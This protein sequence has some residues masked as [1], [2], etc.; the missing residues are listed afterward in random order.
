MSDAPEVTF[1]APVKKKKVVKKK[2][3]RAAK[4]DTRPSA[5]F[6]GLAR[7]TGSAT[8]CADACNADGCAISGKNYCAHPAKGGLQSAD[9]ND[10][11]ALKRLKKAQD[12]LDIRLDPD[13]FK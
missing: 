1:D 7:P 12:Q 8:G 13:R 5:P 11:A 3:K 10:S 4:P 9:M 2:A 6:P